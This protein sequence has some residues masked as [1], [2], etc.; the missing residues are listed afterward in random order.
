MPLMG[1]EFSKM[2]KKSSSRRKTL[3]KMYKESDSEPATLPSSGSRSIPELSYQ[4]SRSEGNTTT[5]DAED[6]A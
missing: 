6:E 1:F 3:F 2:T 5:E 4:A